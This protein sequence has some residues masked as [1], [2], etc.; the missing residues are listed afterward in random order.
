MIRKNWGGGQRVCIG[1]LLRHL[2]DGC[3]FAT[4]KEKWAV[5]LSMEC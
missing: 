2:S 3:Q 1:P 4:R 5:L